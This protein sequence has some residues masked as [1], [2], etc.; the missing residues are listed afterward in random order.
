LRGDFKKAGTAMRNLY[1]KLEMD[2]MFS[3][4]RV[5]SAY[6][7][8]TAT[9]GFTLFNFGIGADMVR[10]G[11]TLFSMQLALNNMADIAYQN[12]LSRL[13]YTADNLA[14]GRTGVFNMG[15]NFSIRMNI[16]MEFKIK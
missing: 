16:P 7:T 5:F 2:N 4:N 11:R 1:V 12:H 8:E 13:K 9:N 15:R 14:T 10:K 3:Q 6:N